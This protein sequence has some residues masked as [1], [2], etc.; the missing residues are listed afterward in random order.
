LSKTES[1]DSG[2]KYYHVNLA[3]AETPK[4][5]TVSTWRHPTAMIP[6]LN[7]PKLQKDVRGSADPTHLKS[8]HGGFDTLNTPTDPPDSAVLPS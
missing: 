7:H 3:S 2:K 4:N 5:V 1:S 6:K 8:N